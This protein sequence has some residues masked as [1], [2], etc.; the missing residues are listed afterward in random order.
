VL[1]SAIC[2]LFSFDTSFSRSIY[3]KK[4]M[5]RR[6]GGASSL[7]KLQQMIDAGD[8]Y[9]AQLTYKALAFRATKRKDYNEAC[10]ILL[11][12]CEAL[13][14]VEKESGASDLAQPLIKVKILSLLVAFV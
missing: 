3:R 5:P 7:A 6:K 2:W 1:T 11:A 13:L 4:K 10:V 12:G 9:N 14:K 8:A